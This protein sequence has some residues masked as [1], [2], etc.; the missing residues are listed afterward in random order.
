MEKQELYEKNLHEIQ[1]FVIAMN[2]LQDEI[3]QESKD[4]FTQQ[5]RQDTELMLDL[6]EKRKMSIE[7]QERFLTY[8]RE[9]LGE[10]LGEKKTNA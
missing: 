4:A 8:L 5:I 2:L 6:I 9:L 7:T 1:E 10:L 3:S